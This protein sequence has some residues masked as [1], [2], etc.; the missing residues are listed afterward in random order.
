MTPEQLNLIYD[1][2]FS[3]LQM[4]EDELA[5][6]A[7]NLTA[8]DKAAILAGAGKARQV[9]AIIEEELEECQKNT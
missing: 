1:V 5:L 3:C 2:A 9:L 8:F 7:H 4:W 6:S